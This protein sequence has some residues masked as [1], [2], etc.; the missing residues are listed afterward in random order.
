MVPS[1]SD[2]LSEATIVM[3]CRRMTASTAAR[4]TPGA[5]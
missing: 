1:V 4:V 5:M 2:M 3:L